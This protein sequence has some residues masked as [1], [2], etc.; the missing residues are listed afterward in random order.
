MSIDLRTTNRIAIVALMWVACVSCVERKEHLS[1]SPSGGVMY[2]IM[3]AS[4]SPTDLY[5]GDAV[6]LIAGGWVAQQ[7]VERDEEGKE[8]FQL[9]AQRFLA[10]GAELPWSFALAHDADAEAYLQ[11][12]TTVTIEE[13]PDGT[14][15]HFSR[16]Y[17]GREWAAIEVLR[18]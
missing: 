14:Y 17:G 16:R 18:Q 11:F 8:K 7:I 15:Y 2:K 4:E 9:R 5:E 3:Y 10:P 1:I 6:P 12:P 13:R